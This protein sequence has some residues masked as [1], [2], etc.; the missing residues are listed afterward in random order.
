MDPPQRSATQKSSPSRSSVSSWDSTKIRSSLRT[1]RHYAHYFPNLAPSLIA[2]FIAKIR[3]KLLRLA[4][5]ELPVAVSYTVLAAPLLY[6]TWRGLR[7]APVPCRRE[8]LI[9]SLKGG[10]STVLM[11]QG[12]R[13]EDHRRSGQQ[14]PAFHWEPLLR[15][16]VLA[17]RRQT[18]SQ[19][20]TAKGRYA[21]DRVVYSHRQG[22]VREASH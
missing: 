15:P 20:H 3:Y 8:F 2:T 9:L 12:K 10:T 18:A 7:F 19:E 4:T 13:E 6:H 21:G 5:A 14:A 16:T 22:S 1:W 11:A 17:A